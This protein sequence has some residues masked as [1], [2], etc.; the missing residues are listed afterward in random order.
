MGGHPERFP[1]IPRDLRRHVRCTT[2]LVISSGKGA[3]V[4]A[5]NF[6][7]ELP[8]WNDGSGREASCSRAVPDPRHVLFDVRSERAWPRG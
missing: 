8:M 1:G 7:P 5:I 2:S 3:R 6:R 4:I